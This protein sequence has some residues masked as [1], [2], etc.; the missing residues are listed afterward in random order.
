[1]YATIQSN[2]AMRKFL[3]GAAALLLGIASTAAPANPGAVDVRSV[4]VHFGELDLSRSEGA[5]V[6]YRRIQRAAYDVC[7]GYVGPFPEM[8][9]KTGPCYTTA[10]ANAV[11]QVNSP[12]LSAIY[13]A[14]M[15]RLASN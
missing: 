1:M 12:Q 4:T 6:L 15:P 10:V 5:Q 11:A 3:I 7:D 9:I 8:H 2:D 14:H 13:R